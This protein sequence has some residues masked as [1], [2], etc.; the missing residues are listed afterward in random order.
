MI[1]KQEEATMQIFAY[2]FSRYM[3]ANGIKYTEQKENV[4]KVV[5][6]G[7]NLSSIPVYVFFD[8]D[9]APYVQFKCWDIQ[10]FKNNEAAAL[11]VC[12]ELNAE[13]RWVKFYLDGDKDIVASIDAVIDMNT[14]GEVCLNLV[15]RVVNIVDEAYPQIAKARWA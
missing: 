15:R 9:N 13:Y 12:N 4:L 11:V 3:D 7:D 14:C 6:N 2:E 8:E 5:Y 10:S 1:K